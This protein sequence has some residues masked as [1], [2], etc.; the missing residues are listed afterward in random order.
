M[1]KI[2]FALCIFFSLFLFLPSANAH[3]QT[4]DIYFFWGDGCPH[5]AKEKL[6]LEDLQ[7]E[8]GGR[9]AIHSYEVWYNTD[10]QDLL[11]SMARK[12]GQEVSGVPALFIGDTLL[13]GFGSADTTGV[14]IRQAIDLLLGQPIEIPVV[15]LNEEKEAIN[16][17]TVIVPVFGSVDPRQFSLPVLTTVIAAID[18]FNPCAMWVLVL[19]IGMLIGMQNRK[20]LWVLGGLFI[21]TSGL[22]Y[23]VFLSA[24]LNVFKIIGVLRWIQVLV[25]LFALGVGVYYVHRFW[26]TKPGECDVSNSGQKKTIYNRIG[27]IVHKQSLFLSIIGIIILA[28]MVN[29]IE[30]ACS[31][32]LPA[33]YTQVLALSDVSTWTHYAYLLLYVFVFMLDDM[34]VFAVAVTSLRSIG[35]SGKFSH[36]ATLVGG[37]IIFALGALLLIKPS[38][39][40]FG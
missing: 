34:F 30:L 4:A 22:V 8:F 13:V 9:V 15:N 32:G 37:I 10:N 2:F 28:F 31:A 40:M 3:E 5:C 12:L 16:L 35:L 36:I 19:L 21:L 24:W 20:R 39:L 14:E 33:I 23:F 6:F 38:L 7:Q 26:T 1:K 29:L 27:D 18:G 25:G 11:V 17:E